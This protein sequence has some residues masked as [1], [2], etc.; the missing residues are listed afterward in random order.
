MRGG[1]QVVVDEIYSMRN[2]R[3]EAGA[4]KRV[5]DRNICEANSQILSLPTAHCRCFIRFRTKG[6]TQLLR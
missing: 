5:A 4:D 6:S 1:P 2:M 3:G